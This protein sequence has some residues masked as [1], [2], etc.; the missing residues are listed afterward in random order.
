MSAPT[1][2]AG[3]SDAEVTARLDRVVADFGL[4]DV[5]PPSSAS[6]MRRRR[7][8]DA[9]A[10]SG[11]ATLALVREDGLV[12]WIY[13]PP[14]RGGSGRRARR[15]AA[16]EIGA[17]RVHAFSFRELPPNEVLDAFEKL[18]AKLTPAQGLRRLRNGKWEPA[19]GIKVA[20]RV[21]LFVHG[22]FS[23][24]EMY[25]EELAATAEGSALLAK[26]QKKYDAVL[27]FDHPTLSVSPWINALDL[28]AALANVTATFD[29]VAHSRGGLVAAWWMRNGLRKV[30]NV[31]FVGTPLTGT[32]LASPPKLRQAL[33]MLANTFRALELAGAAA[34][35][36][37]PMMG[38][39]TGIAKI[40]GGALRLGAR[41]PV[42]DAGVAIVPGL[43]AQSRVSN[44]A[45]LIRLAG[46]A[47]ASSPTC[48]A[49]LSNFEA[50]S[51]AAPWW[52]FWK[53]FRGL[54]SA[55]LDTGADA[56]FKGDNDLVVDTDAMT[57][58]RNARI[59]ASRVLDF[60]TNGVVHHCSYFRQPRTVALMERAF[61]L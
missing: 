2:P 33:D 7:G 17:E 47:W 5:P 10:Y 23:K 60:G 41:L 58:V 21:L 29:V 45:E 22:T 26:A 43:A 37:A 61:K 48:Y 42:A 53:H 49:V 54:G 19:D 18:D 27:A 20:G 35:T 57:L 36:V 11:L 1:P 40:V 59:P 51:N 39:V 56:I 12:R 25:L 52:Q 6:A 30:E 4:A 31:I 32:S 44:N 28:E 24:S 38:A 8:F 15:A 3:V 14:A 16:C 50:P 13:E 46:T 9:E 34:S 55:L